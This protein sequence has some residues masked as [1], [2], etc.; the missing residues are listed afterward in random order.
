MVLAEL[1]RRK[2]LEPLREKNREQRERW[3]QEYIAKVRREIEAKVRSEVEA[4]VNLEWREWNNRYLE[5]KAAG[6]PFNEPT[7][8]QKKS[9]NN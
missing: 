7:P 3:R 9:T 8:W 2:Y 5:A 4:K 1:L 6:I